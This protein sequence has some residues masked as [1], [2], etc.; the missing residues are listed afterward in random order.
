[1][2]GDEDVKADEINS[3][4]ISPIGDHPRILASELISG[5]TEQ[6]VNLRTGLNLARRRSFEDIGIDDAE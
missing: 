2:I 1:M 3:S 5:V 4:R 6:S